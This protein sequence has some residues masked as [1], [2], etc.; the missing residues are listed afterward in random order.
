MSLYNEVMENNR[1]IIAEIASKSVQHEFNY[2]EFAKS[3]AFYDIGKNENIMNLLKIVI[4]SVTSVIRNDH[5]GFEHSTIEDFLYY[6]FCLSDS[7]ERGKN[8]YNEMNFR[9]KDIGDLI[10]EIKEADDEIKRGKRINEI[11]ETI[12]RLEEEKISLN[13]VATTK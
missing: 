11:N 3:L 13:K 5:D 12:K 10:K 2:L 7:W 6:I 9:D 8:G 4:A 1:N